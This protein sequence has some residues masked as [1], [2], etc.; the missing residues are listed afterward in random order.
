MYDKEQTARF[1]CLKLVMGMTD[2][3]V[4]NAD[5]VIE[6]AN[7]F[8]EFVLSGELLAAPEADKQEA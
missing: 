6:W 7:A 3:D 5:Q 2:V 1:E 8:A 4:M